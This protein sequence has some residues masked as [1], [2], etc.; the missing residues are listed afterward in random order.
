MV[1]YSAPI[2]RKGRVVGV[3]DVDLDLDSLL[4]QLHSLRPGGDGTA[5]MVNRKGRILAHPKL[6]P[7]ADLPESDTL[8]ELGALMKRGGV[9]AEEMSDPV[10]HRRSWVV[11][12]PIASLSTTRGGEDWSLIVSWPLKQRMAPLNGMV[13]RLLVLYLFLGGA[14][15]WFLNRL[16][17][18]TI[19]RPL[20]QLAE[21]ATSYAEGNFNQSQAPLAD[22]LEL[23]ELGSA[24]N[25][26]G[27]ALNKS[28]KSS[29][30]TGE[31]P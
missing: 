10:S 19:T 15:I 3:A 20:R 25:A 26:L 22:T 17:D 18:D 24:L 4:K 30:S 8:N 12:S 21:Q 2:R 31:S 28:D 16:L 27:T 1:S 7:L 29:T 9:D 14:A 5:Y 11:E 6:K 23:R 13:R